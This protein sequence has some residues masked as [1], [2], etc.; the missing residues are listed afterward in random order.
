MSLYQYKAID[1][2]GEEITGMMDSPDE[3]HV[4]NHLTAKGLIV[5]SIKPKGA[6][7]FL[8]TLKSLGYKSSRVSKLDLIIFTRQ[9]ASL[10]DAGIPVNSALR[11]LSKQSAGRSIV[12]LAED[13]KEELESGSTITRALMKRRDV[14]SDSYISMVEAGEAGGMLPEVFSRLATILEIEKERREKIKSAVTY[15]IILII[16]AVGGMT[17]L[18]V[19]VF[20]TFVKIFT[21]AHIRLPW[22]TRSLILVSELVKAY[23]PII[24]GVVIALVVFI[25]WYSRTEEG[26]MKIDGLKLKLPIFGPL[27]EKVAMSTFAH[28]YRALNSSGIPLSRT[29]EIVSGTVGNKIISKAIL[30]VIEKIKGGA[31]IARPFEESGCFPPFVVH[32]ISVGEESGRMDEML[33]KVSEYYDKEVNYSITKLTNSLEPALIGV[34][35][36]VVAFMYLSLIT[37]M[38]QMM[39][40]ARAGGLG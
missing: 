3:I 23:Y 38:M 19:S 21:R 4:L 31:T 1:D 5:S 17:F 32:M 18:V 2:R 20:P 11:I 13:I 16:A 24:I 15:P 25:R 34:M 7:S 35:G 26:Q 29:L 22:T 14:F 37:P 36:G 12:E 28:N 40:V 6:G 33:D 27:F 30:D 39:K 9:M 10:L 8:D